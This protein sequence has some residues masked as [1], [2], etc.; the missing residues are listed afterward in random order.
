MYEMPALILR[1]GVIAGLILTIIGV[2][3]EYLLDINIV[4]ELGLLAIVLAP[5]ISL[6]AISIALLLRKDIYGFILSQ[7]AIV[8]ILASI[9]ISFC[10]R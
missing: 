9:I 1:Y 2:I 7:L 8:V 3:V 10:D 4:V 5:I 6:F